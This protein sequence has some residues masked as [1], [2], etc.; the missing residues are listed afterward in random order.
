MREGTRK[1]GTRR[2]GSIWGVNNYFKKKRKEKKERKE[3]KKTYA[4]SMELSRQRRLNL[5]LFWLLVVN[6]AS[7]N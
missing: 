6:L 5:L 3:K 1:G 7:K 2:E 4:I